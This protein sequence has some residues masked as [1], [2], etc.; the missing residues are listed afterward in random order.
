[1]KKFKLLLLA[2]LSVL[3]MG[4]FVGCGK[5]AEPTESDVREAL[6]DE[7]YLS[8]DKDEDDDAE[9]DS[10]KEEKKVELK[11]TKC[12]L[13]DDKDKATVT[14]SVYETVG[15]MEIEKE[16]K[17]TFRLNDSKKWK[18]KDVEE[19]DKTEKLVKGSSDEEAL[20]ELSLGSYDVETTSVFGSNCTFDNIKHELNEEKKVD[21]VTADAKATV[22]VKELEFTVEMELEYLGNSWS[23][24]EYKV[25]KA[26]TKYADNYKLDLSKDSVEKDIKKYGETNNGYLIGKTVKYSDMTFTEI[27]CA[28]WTP[29]GD[30]YVTIEADIALEYAGCKFTHKYSLRYSYKPESGWELTNIYAPTGNCELVSAPL[31][32]QYE[33]KYR[34]DSMSLEITEGTDGNYAAKVTI[35]TTGSQGTYAYVGEIKKSSVRFN[36]NAIYFKV[37]GTEM[38]QQPADGKL[39]NCLKSFSVNLDGNDLYNKSYKI[40][41]KKK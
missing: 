5:V 19:G 39:S 1:M 13:N 33:G 24:R 41:L 26:E 2:L 38:T 34:D 14:A 25:T 22:G 40:E 35:A 30:K 4:L 18:V 17:V 20:H 11:I 36:D 7:G 12:K 8:D 29:N 15:P 27:K 21:V 6:E 31:V 16:Y 28:E 9:D 37:E 3:V 32:A 23:R 10:A